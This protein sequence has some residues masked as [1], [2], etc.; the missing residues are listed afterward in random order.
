MMRAMTADPGSVTGFEYDGATYRLIATDSLRKIQ[1]YEV[2][3][4]VAAGL[5]DCADRDEALAMHILARYA[6]TEVGVTPWSP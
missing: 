3:P 4:G 2:P 1:F 5:A 6:W